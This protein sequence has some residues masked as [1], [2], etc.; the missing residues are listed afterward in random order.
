[1]KALNQFNKGETGKVKL[2]REGKEMELSVT[3]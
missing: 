2:L 1:M 3:F